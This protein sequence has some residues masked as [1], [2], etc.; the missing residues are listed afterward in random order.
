MFPQTGG[1]CFF[2]PSRGSC[3]SDEAFVDAGILWEE[4]QR[5][6]YPLLRYPQVQGDH[7]ECEELGQREG[8]KGSNRLL[9]GIQEAL[10]GAI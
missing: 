10:Q 7:Q 3:G 4:R 6:E 8:F 2:R 1:R 5:E 9:R